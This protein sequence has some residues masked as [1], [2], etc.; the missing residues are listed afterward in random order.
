MAMG[1]ERQV[2]GKE[3]WI[4]VGRQCQGSP[5]SGA[6]GRRGRRK[7]KQTEQK[8][9]ES[10][11]I[12]KEK[13]ISLLHRTSAAPNELVVAAQRVKTSAHRRLKLKFGCK[14]DFENN[15]RGANLVSNSLIATSSNKTKC[16]LCY[17][18]LG[19][20]KFG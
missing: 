2:Y 11:S 1:N 9:K 10:D 4:A 7:S 18:G 16:F 17:N 15:I 6:H 19:S 8:V 3:I 5:R 20:S 12:K 14:D 13:T